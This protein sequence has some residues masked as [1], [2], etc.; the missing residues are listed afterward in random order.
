MAN[1]YRVVKGV[2]DTAVLSGALKWNPSR[3]VKLPR[4]DRREMSVLT[5]D[6]VEAVAHAITDPPNR[7]G[8]YP[9]YG[10]LVRFAAYTG[11]RAA[12]VA[13][14][15]A[16]RVDLFRGTVHVV[17]T[18]VAVR[19]GVLLERQP[20]KTRQGQRVVMPRFLAEQLA[21]HLGP[22][23]A[24]PDAL[25]FPGPDGGPHNQGRWYPAHFRPAVRHAGI[26]R[27]VRF[28]DLRHTCASL[29]IANGA[30][31]RAIMEQLGHSTITVTMNTYGHLFPTTMS[32]LA[33]AMEAMYQATQYSSDDAGSPSA[34]GTLRELS[35]ASGR[36]PR[37]NH[38]SG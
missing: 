11:L 29:L 17:E 20:T 14:L 19:G 33:D 9:A 13:G 21:E 36:T 28:H 25:V 37:E 16:G 6:E 3:K 15:R 24:S 18:T 27:P 30:H 32:D 31:P 4:A 7:D 5:S 8:T 34:R 12:E 10:L 23:A 22:R 26:D 38:G 35:R 1:A 2:L